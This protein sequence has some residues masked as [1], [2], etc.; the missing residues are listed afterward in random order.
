MISQCRG[1]T[2]Q[3]AFLNVLVLSL[4]LSFCVSCGDPSGKI[5]NR[6]DNRAEEDALKMDSS[7]YKFPTQMP[8]AKAEVEQ[9]FWRCAHT[10]SPDKSYHFNIVIPRDWRPVDAPSELPTQAKPLAS[11][12]F[13]R[14]QAEPR[15][16]IEVSATLLPR[17][18]APGDWLDLYLER[19]G[20]RVLSRRE[21]KTSGGIVADVLTRA[22]TPDGA[23]VSRWLAVKDL[24]RL[25]VLQARTVEQNYPVFAD[26]FFMG[27]AG[28]A[29][30][31][32]SEWELAERLSTFSRA[33]PGDFLIY[34][35][36]SW[37]LVQD[38][39]SNENALVLEIKNQ[40]GTENA[41]EDATVGR[42]VVTIVKRAAESS[43][44][45]LADNFADDLRRNGIEL[46]GTTL[47]P[48]PAVGGLQAM[49]QATPRATKNSMPVDVRIVVGQQHDAWYLFGLYGPARETL[50]EAWM[51]N[52]RAFEIIVERLKTLPAPAG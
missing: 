39:S 38:D 21:M 47:A 4:M 36:E 40:V 37:Q 42:V 18:I 35:P 20:Q 7:A 5:E 45:R 28:F 19:A 25:F 32:P 23:V 26:V 49:W 43:A 11:V 24:N 31:H 27:V 22:D 41:G 1:G 34:Y 29:L 2:Q 44:Q 17:E 52:K 46:N 51:M 10:L 12:A 9:K 6:D 50:P 16:E 3:V 15:G 8:F 14:N 33:V 30:M 13:F 48:A